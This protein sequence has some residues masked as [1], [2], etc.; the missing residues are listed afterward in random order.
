MT[1]KVI[2]STLHRV[3]RGHGKGFASEPRRGPV[4]RPARVAIML[5]LAHKI[6]DAIARGQV[7]SQAEVAR[8]LDLTPARL[9][10]LLDLLRLSPDIQER[11][12]FLEA[13]DGVEPL[14]ERALRVVT[15][16]SSWVEQRVVFDHHSLA[17][18]GSRRR[19]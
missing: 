17:A 10:Q 11:V 19:D 2:T 5:A 9:T 3:Q 16:V 13:I 15:H 14:T 8:R 1:G 18:E 7:H 12:L 4:R 6:R